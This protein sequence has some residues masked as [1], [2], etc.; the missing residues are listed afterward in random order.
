MWDRAAHLADHKLG[1]KFVDGA[2]ATIIE[3]FIQGM[4][5]MKVDSTMMLG[6]VVKWVLLSLKIIPKHTSRFWVFKP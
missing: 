2:E 5:I 1:W 3:D 6:E 4:E